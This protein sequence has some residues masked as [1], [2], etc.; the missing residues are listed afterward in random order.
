LN[1]ARDTANRGEPIQIVA[2]EIRIR[3]FGMASGQRIRNPVLHQIVA[4]RHFSAEAVAPVANGHAAR[5]VRRSLHQNRHAQPGHSQGVRHGAFIAEVGQRDDDAVNL[6]AMLLK[7][8]RAAGGF[9]S[10]FDGAVFGLFG[11]NRNHPIA[12]LLNGCDHFRAPA[13]G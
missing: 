13:L 3:R 12:G 1:P 11:T 9:R 10:G 6:A 4:D 2:E 5:R 7:Q 8:L